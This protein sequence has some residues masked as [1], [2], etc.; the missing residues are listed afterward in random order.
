[1]ARVAAIPPECPRTARRRAGP[2]RPPFESAPASAV[3]SS[4]L[5]AARTTASAGRA[6]TGGGRARPGRGGAPRGGAGCRRTGSAASAYQVL[7]RSSSG[8]GWRASSKTSVRS[9]QPAMLAGMIAPGAN[10][11][12]RRGKSVRRRASSAAPVR[13]AALLG[14]EVVP[15][16]SASLQHRGDVSDA[17]KMGPGDLARNPAYSGRAGYGKTGTGEQRVTRPLRRPGKYASRRVAGQERPRE[18]WIEIPVPALVSAEL[19][20]GARAVGGEPDQRDGR[21]SRRCCR[22]C[23]CA[24]AADM[25]TTGRRRGRR[26]GSCTTTA[27][28]ARTAGARGARVAEPAGAPGPAGRGGVGR[29]GE[30]AGRSGA[31]EAELS[32]G[33]RRG[34]G[35]IRDSGGWPTARG[36]EAVGTSGRPAVTAYQEE[37]DRAGRVAPADA[38]ATESDAGGG[39][40]TGSGRERRRG[41]GAAPAGRRDAGEFPG[42]VAGRRRDALGSGSGRRCYAHW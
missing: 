22:A 37:L 16:G 32:V 9:A 2:R 25:R 14:P 1:M 7:G 31:T 4:R 30:V 35:R 27:A 10:H 33:W 26:S 41:T 19:R 8:A 11:R 36:A 28:W 3:T 42:T 24:G 15:T 6:W 29:V 38:A 34:A 5:S 18:E 17:A 13:G 20:A 21:R 40:R 23:W 39:G 12:S